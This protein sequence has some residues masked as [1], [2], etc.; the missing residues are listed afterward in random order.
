[1]TE[2]SSPLHAFHLSVKDLVEFCCREGDLMLSF[3]RSPSAQEGIRGHQKVQANRP[4]SYQSEV[5][6]RHI[7]CRGKIELNL[8]GRIDGV[9]AEDDPVIIEEIKTTYYQ[10][11][12][13]PPA[14]RTLH[15]AQ[16]KIYAYIYCLKE[17]LEQCEVRVTY[18]HLESRKEGLPSRN[19][20][21]RK[22]DGIF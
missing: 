12:S 3:G 21:S 6:V 2:E 4:E 15:D 19:A 20:V 14:V 1:M 22:T 10:V 5:T 16:A 13:L 7:H 8:S 18:F 11:D 9:F 17:D